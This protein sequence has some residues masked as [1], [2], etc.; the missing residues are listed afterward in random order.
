VKPIYPE[1]DKKGSDRLIRVATAWNEPMAH[2]WA[3]MLRNNG[4][5]AFVKVGGAGFSFGGPPPFGSEAY[6]F[7]P[8]RL[9]ERACAI[10][11]AF[12]EP[13]VLQL[14]RP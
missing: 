1:A 12:E 6:V 13:G 9:A 4:V 2:S 3:E 10:L 8:Q 11:E 14:L 7:V 5:D